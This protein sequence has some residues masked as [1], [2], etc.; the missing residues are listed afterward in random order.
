M[1]Q[2]N[3]LRIGNLVERFD[4][5]VLNGIDL[6]RKWVSYEILS[7]DIVEV[8]MFPDH[9]RPVTLT[10]EWLLKFGFEVTYDSDF[11]K[12]FDHNEFTEF[13][14]DIPKTQDKS[15]EGFRYYGRYIKIKSVHQLQNL[16]FALTGTELTGKPE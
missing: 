10:E 9:Y 16:Y 11:R 2:A 1:I 13:G 5:Q 15:M 12:K 14:Y 8:T 4:F 3:E 7:V 6:P